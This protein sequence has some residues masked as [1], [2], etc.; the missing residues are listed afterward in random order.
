M[1][2]LKCKTDQTRFQGAEM[3]GKRVK[4]GGLEECEKDVCGGH[5]K[6]AGKK[7]L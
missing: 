4:E 3:D 5:T 7:L 1:G 2:C 6:A